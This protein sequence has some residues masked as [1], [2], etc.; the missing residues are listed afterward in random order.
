MIAKPTNDAKCQA[1]LTLEAINE[2]IVRDFTSLGQN[3]LNVATLLMPCVLLL[4][5]SSHFQNDSN[6][7]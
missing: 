6:L 4:F 7:V 5:G 3:G 1:N 2:E